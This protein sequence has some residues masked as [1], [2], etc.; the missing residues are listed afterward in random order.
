[1]HAGTL[2]ESAQTALAVLGKSK[3]LSKCYLAGGSALALCLGHRKSFDFDFYTR[4]NFSAENIAVALSKIGKFETTLL[5][6]PHT[7]LGIFNGVRFSLFLYDY[8]LIGITT[9]YQT[10]TVAGLQDIAAMKLS[11]IAGRA[12]KRDY[13]DIYVISQSISLEQQLE[14]YHKK[15]Y[16]L[17][18]NPYVIIKALGYFEDAEDDNMPIMITKISW[19]EVKKILSLESQRLARKFITTS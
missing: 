5:E 18:N 14:W 10:V 6:P 4:S 19:E 15:F 9:N 13:V 8:P 2:S 12:T 16:K 17:G 3:I 11:A 1:M 7:L